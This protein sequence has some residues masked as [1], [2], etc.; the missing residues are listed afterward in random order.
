MKARSCPPITSAPCAAS[1]PTSLK[2]KLN[3]HP[4][5]NINLK[6]KDLTCPKVLKIHSIAEEY[7][8]KDYFVFQNISQIKTAVDILTIFHICIEFSVAVCPACNIKADICPFVYIFVALNFTFCV[9]LFD[10]AAVIIIFFSCIIFF[11]IFVDCR[12]VFIVC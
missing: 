5:Q 10:C 2:K 9:R 1:A 4:C 7:S 11:E 6:I 8:N 3:K 12:N